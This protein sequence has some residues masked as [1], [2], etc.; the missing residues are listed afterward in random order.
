MLRS[1]AKMLCLCSALDS[2]YR[3]NRAKM[4]LVVSLEVKAGTS[5]MSIWT[6]NH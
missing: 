1:A 2:I 5:C 6:E 4:R 3:A